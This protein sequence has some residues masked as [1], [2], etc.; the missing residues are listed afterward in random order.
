[1]FN[2]N[3][4]FENS[5]VMIITTGYYKNEAFIKNLH[6]NIYV[7]IQFYYNVEYDVPSFIQEYE[8]TI[9]E[10]N[11][12]FNTRTNLIF[13]APNE[14]VNKIILGLNYTSIVLNHN[15]FIDY[16][17]FKITN[18]SNNRKY[19]AVINSRPF[20]WKRVY[21]ALKIDNL[22]YIKGEDW[23][24]DKM[25][26]HGWKDHKFKH[27]LDNG[28]LKEVCNVYNNSNVG[29]LLSGHTGEHRQAG[30]EGANFSSC[31]YLLCGLPIVST[32]SQGGRD[33]WFDETNSIIC[34]PNE[35]D[36]LDKCNIMLSRIRENKI[37]RQQIRNNQIHKIN[38]LRLN[39]IKKV[40]EIFSKYNIHI[41]STD[42]F[43]RNY[44]H[45]MTDYDV[46][47]DELI[48]RMNRLI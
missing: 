35:D 20:W 38:K 11:T 9:R 28:G 8:D 27:L 39:F 34:E 18:S 15:C 3:V 26:W 29:L 23:A 45:K 10:H 33:Y 30:C 19:D 48:S 12:T 25:S 13:C 22:A 24:N 16:N 5:N 32:P 2:A 31:E 14:E 47:I 4:Y 6:N 37:D 41:D 36:V 1:M 7:F 44:R 46:N 40:S 21:L 42:Y 43:N 17:L